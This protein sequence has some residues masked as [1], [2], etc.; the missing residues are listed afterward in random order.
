MKKFLQTLD[1]NTAIVVVIGLV[2]SIYVFSYQL[3][4][5]SASS[6]FSQAEQTFAQGTADL[7]NDLGDTAI[8]VGSI[9]AASWGL[10][11][12]W[13]LIFA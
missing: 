10:Y 1:R 2:L 8:A 13:P 11:L 12:L 5:S 3:F 7:E 4:N 9:G 6:G